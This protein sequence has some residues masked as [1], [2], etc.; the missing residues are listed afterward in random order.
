MSLATSREINTTTYQGACRRDY[1][2]VTSWLPVRL[3]GLDHEEATKLTLE[4]NLPGEESASLSDRQLEARL[5]QIEHKLDLLLERAGFD[6]ELPLSQTKKREVELSGS[7]IRVEADG[8]YRVG[9]LVKVELYLPEERGRSIC[10]LGRIIVGNEARCQDSKLGVALV[11]QSI[12]DGDREAI[13]RHAYEVQR[14]S[15]G[16]ASRR[17]HLR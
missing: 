2:R 5:C 15:L 11:F 6:V 3:T 10:L 1:F 9:D 4:L 14:L 17:D 13:V 12:R 7:G 8:N 16:R